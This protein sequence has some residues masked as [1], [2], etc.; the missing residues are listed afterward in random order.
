MEGIQS[1]VGGMDATTLQAEL[2]G[3]S[4][5][6]VVEAATMIDVD[7]E[8]DE[9]ELEQELEQWTSPSSSL[10]ENNKSSSSNVGI[11]VES[12]DADDEISI[13]SLPK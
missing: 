10:P 6:P 1:A 12:N 2:E 5:Q 11:S 7:M 3:L 13:L 4:G 8:F 9:H